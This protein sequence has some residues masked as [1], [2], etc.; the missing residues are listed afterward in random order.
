MANT[1]ISALASASALKR[2]ALLPSGVN[3][4]L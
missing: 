1:K 3:G 2:Q 4:P